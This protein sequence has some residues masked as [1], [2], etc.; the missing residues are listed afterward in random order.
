MFLGM[1]QNEG[2][3]CGMGKRAEG[4]EGKGGKQMEDSLH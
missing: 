2:G 4:G 3:D 1:G